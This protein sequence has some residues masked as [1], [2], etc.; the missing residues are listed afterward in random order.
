MSNS[1]FVRSEGSGFEQNID[2]GET[3][4]ISD[5]SAL[6]EK[7]DGTIQDSPYFFSIDHQVFSVTSRDTMSKVNDKSPV[8]KTES[9]FPKTNAVLPDFLSRK[10]KKS[11]KHNDKKGY[12]MLSN[13]VENSEVTK[14]RERDIDSF[15]TS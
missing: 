1:N 9:V 2:N 14:Y 12:K 13:N 7:S 15:I 10:I 6:F 4:I 5:F 8:I 11:D 3:I